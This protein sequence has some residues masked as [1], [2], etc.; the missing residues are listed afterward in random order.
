MGIFGVCSWGVHDDDVSCFR[1]VVPSVERERER[2]REREKGTV[3]LCAF[4][5]ILMWDGGGGGDSDRWFE[6]RAFFSEPWTA[7]KRLL[8]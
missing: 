3:P 5:N 8:T 7:R 4:F 2:E 6:T 1:A